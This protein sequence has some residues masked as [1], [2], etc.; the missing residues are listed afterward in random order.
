MATR[1]RK[2]ILD[3]LKVES[4]KAVDTLEPNE[5]KK[6]KKVAAKRQKKATAKKAAF[7]P[8][9][10]VIIDYPQKNDIITGLHYA[11]RIGASDNGAVELSIDSGDWQPCRQGGGFWW[12][13]WGYFT[14]GEHTLVAR[15]RDAEGTTLTKSPKVAVKVV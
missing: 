3:T 4:G 13:D 15:L 2:S 8:T 7:D 6:T 1:K 10:Y 9:C 12:F 14:P 5:P 11:I